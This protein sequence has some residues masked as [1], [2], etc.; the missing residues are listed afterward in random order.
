MPIR[1]QQISGSSP[2]GGSTKSVTVW[3]RSRLTITTSLPLVGISALAG[4]RP[5][6]VHVLPAP[7]DLTAMAN[8]AR[9]ASGSR[10]FTI[11][12]VY[13]E[14]GISGEPQA[15]THRRVPLLLA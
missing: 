4:R 8:G 15:R 14:D 5:T 2:E 12:L 11:T 10:P 3:S 13:G 1:N 7:V 9:A 6:C